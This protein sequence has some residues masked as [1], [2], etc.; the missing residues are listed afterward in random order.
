MVIAT[1]SDAKCAVKTTGTVLGR[2]R[3]RRPG[4]SIGGWAPF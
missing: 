1:G 3:L 2:H 4:S